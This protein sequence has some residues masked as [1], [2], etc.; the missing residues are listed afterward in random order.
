MSLP[1]E[2]ATSGDKAIG[3]IQK[4]LQA[5]GCQ[6][7]GHMMDFEKGELLVQFKFRNLPITVKASIAGYAAAYLKHHPYGHRMRCSRVEH[8]RKAKD[9]ASVAVYSM[10]R[11]WLKGQIT[12]IECG[13]LSVEGAFLGQILLSS[14][15]TVLEEVK[16]R[17]LLPPL[18]EKN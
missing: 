15:N 10:V 11:D 13:I 1:Y 3:E 16:A 12:A 8:E 2:S 9:I 4:I 18:L 14:G 7:F 6:S 5:F 17:E